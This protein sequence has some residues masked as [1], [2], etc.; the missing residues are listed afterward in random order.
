MTLP[1]VAPHRIPPTLRKQ[2]IQQP[3]RVAVPSQRYGC[4]LL[5]AQGSPGCVHVDP[6]ADLGA[7]MWSVRA[8]LE[9]RRRAHP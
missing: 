9:A 3:V 8:R 6:G 4:A 1:T 5:W 2:A 7:Q